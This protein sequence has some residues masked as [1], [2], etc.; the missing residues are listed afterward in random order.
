MLLH[1][2]ASRLFM[3]DRMAQSCW[4]VA[5]NLGNDTEGIL[6]ASLWTANLRDWVKFSGG[7]AQ[8]RRVW[9]AFIRNLVN[10]PDS[11]QL[12]CYTSTTS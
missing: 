6:G 11:E 12:P 5:D 1:Y 4:K 3:P 8:D 10:S 7:L 2:K 9:G